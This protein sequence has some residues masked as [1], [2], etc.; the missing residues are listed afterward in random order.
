MRF[1]WKKFK[2]GKIS[3]VVRNK[4]EFNE[5]MQRCE[6]KGFTWR[7]GRAPTHCDYYT[8]DI[9]KITCAEVGKMGHTVFINMNEKTPKIDY[10]EFALNA[11]AD[12]PE[13]VPTLEEMAA[14]AAVLAIEWQK[15]KE[16]LTAAGA[17]LCDAMAQFGERYAQRL[18]ELKKEQSDNE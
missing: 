9:W 11:P 13:R 16:A 5:F 8:G 10:S 3:V 18:Q 15:I 7:D 2:A 12:V 4:K 1:N 14:V 17:A 6:K